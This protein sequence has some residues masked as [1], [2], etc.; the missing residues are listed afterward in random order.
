MELYYQM[1]NSEDYEKSDEEILK[2]CIFYKTL[3]LEIMNTNNK[4]EK[5]KIL[6]EYAEYEKSKTK[7]IK[8]MITISQ[9]FKDRAIENP[10]LIR[11][12]ISSYHNT[13]NHCLI[14][15]NEKKP[16]SERRKFKEHL[17]ED[18]DY[19]SEGTPTKEKK[20]ELVKKLIG[21]DL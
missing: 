12:Y 5:I 14:C 20:E 19:C 18:L 16:I 4:E 6:K 2:V 7:E 3:F 8:R 9:E 15:L 21:E 17:F 10:N 13:L 1:D 11:T